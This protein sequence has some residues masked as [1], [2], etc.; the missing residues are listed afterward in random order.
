M[1]SAYRELPG[2]S[3]AAARGV[4][5]AITQFV[6]LAMLD[7]AGIGTAVTQREALRE[8]IKQHVMEHLA[9]PALSV[10][11]IALALNCSRRQLYNAFA[12]EPDGVAGYILH[13]RLDGCRH[14][15]DGRA[16]DRRSITEIAFGFG[17]SN[18][19]HFSRVFRAHLG[20][21]PSDY[22]RAAGGMVA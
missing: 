20:M 17:F 5:D 6:H 12:E 3:E 11:A 18:M 19:A 8:R 13:R 21:A 4:G 7:L 15:F 9:D 2:M 10:D 16:H 1:R 22:R 14:A